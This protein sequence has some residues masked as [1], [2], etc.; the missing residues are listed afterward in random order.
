MAGIT[1]PAI[2][3]Y[4]EG[5]L[6]ER[7]PLLVE[8]EGQARQQGL[9]IVGPVEARLLFTLA[10]L[11]GAKRV[12][13]LGACSG[14]SALWLA[15][16]VEPFGGTVE[17]LELDPQRAKLVEGNVSRSSAA[18]RVTLLRGDAL[19]ILPTLRP[20]SY[21]L[22]FNDLL[23]SGAG[24]TGGVPNQVRFLELTLPLLRSGGL[25]L[26]DNVLCDGQVTETSPRGAAAG[27]AEYNRRIAQHPGLETS[28]IPI[29]DGVA[30]SL[31]R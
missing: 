28:F 13:E 12:L 3:R 8:M 7:E 24:Q 23:R 15:A 6:P 22:I 19:E 2:E 4:L 20:G 27:I 25:L 9:P 21:D 16:A 29:R 10:R 5:L 26:S 31:K 14:Y 11:S 1:S 18:G 30:I 17:T